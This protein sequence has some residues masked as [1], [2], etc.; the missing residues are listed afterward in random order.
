MPRLIVTI[1][2]KMDVMLKKRS[3]ETGAPVA[4]IVRE[5][6]EEWGQ[7]RGYDVQN[8]VTWGGSKRKSEDDEPGQP[9]GV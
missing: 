3:D 4:S 5:A 1:T 6:L 8:D 2:K 9:V 7:K